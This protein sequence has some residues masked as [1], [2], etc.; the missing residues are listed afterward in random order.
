MRIT[1]YFLF[2]NTTNSNVSL[3]SVI[4]NN[5]V[6]P[7]KKKGSFHGSNSNVMLPPANII[8]SNRPINSKQKYERHNQS[9]Y[10]CNFLIHN[11]FLSILFVLYSY[12]FLFNNFFHILYFS[13]CP[14]LE[15]F[16][17]YFVTFLKSCF[18]PII[19]FFYFCY[20]LF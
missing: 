4:A 6:N 14:C 15:D 18:V 20:A 9:Y 12:C 7:R 13:I 2:S 10:W 5:I 8:E 19:V 16:C 11:T 17:D 3:L 1:N